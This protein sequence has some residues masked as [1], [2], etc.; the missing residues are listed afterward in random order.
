MRGTFPMLDWTMPLPVQTV[1]FSLS[2]LSLL[3]ICGIISELNVDDEDKNGGKNFKDQ[4]TFRNKNIGCYFLRFDI[5][6]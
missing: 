5:V 3:R 6:V 2:L 4:M 1:D